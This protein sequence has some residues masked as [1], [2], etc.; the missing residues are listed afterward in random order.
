MEGRRERRSARWFFI[1]FNRVECWGVVLCEVWAVSCELSN[2]HDRW[3]ACGLAVVYRVTFWW[4]KLLSKGFLSQLKEDRVNKQWT[5]VAVMED[6]YLCYTIYCTSAMPLTLL[7][8]W[9]TM[10]FTMVQPLE[11]PSV[12]DQMGGLMMRH[13][14][15]PLADLSFVVFLLL[16]VQS[17]LDEKIAHTLHAIFAHDMTAFLDGKLFI[18]DKPLC[19]PKTHPPLTAMKEDCQGYLP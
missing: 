15:L 6:S 4:Y 16:C 2:F 14:S 8:C 5:Y 9:G 1:P 11:W 7:C 18:F 13:S 10:V 3:K 19:G 17:C 12:I